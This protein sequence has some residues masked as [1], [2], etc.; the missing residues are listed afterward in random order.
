[1]TKPV[2]KLGSN[3]LEAGFEG[4]GQVGSRL[5]ENDYSEL[6]LDELT[7]DTFVKAGKAEQGIGQADRIITF[8]DDYVSDVKDYVQGNSKRELK[9]KRLDNAVQKEINSRMDKVKNTYR[10]LGKHFDLSN[11]E[12]QA[13]FKFVLNA[14]FKDEENE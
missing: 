5:S 2:T 9:G 13:D 3:I 10:E 7:F 14:L 1:M 11:Q 12:G 6:F 8:T 4:S